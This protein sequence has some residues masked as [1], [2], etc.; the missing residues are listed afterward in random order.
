MREAMLT[1]CARYLLL[2]KKR[3]QVCPSKSD[4]ALVVGGL[5]AP[6]STCRPK[7]KQRP[8]TSPNPT[9]RNGHSSSPANPSRN[10]HQALDPVAGFHLRNGATLHALHWRANP[11]ARGMHESGGIM[12][13]RSP[14]VPPTPSDTAPM[15][16][17]RPHT[18]ANGHTHAHKHTDTHRR[19]CRL[20]MCTSSRPSTPTTRH[21]L[22]P[23]RW[24][25]A[26]RC[27]RS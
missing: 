22:L 23:A 17:P 12:V 24:R 20:T 26:P 21:T 14:R 3:Q 7:P 13:S 2:G 25:Q 11:T 9:L 5:P 4:S 8:H 6:S 1:L 15:R 16:R 27:G 18:S 10:P 19:T